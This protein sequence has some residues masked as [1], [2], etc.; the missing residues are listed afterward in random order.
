[1]RKVDDLGRVVIPMEI[2]EQLHLAQGT[3][4]DFTVKNGCVIMKP[5]D[6]RATAAIRKTTSCSRS[7]ISSC[8]R[9]V[10]NSLPALR[11]TNNFCPE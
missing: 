11:R 10:S 7:A 1:M 4:M 8:A 2:R 6:R 5:V 3:P 9:A